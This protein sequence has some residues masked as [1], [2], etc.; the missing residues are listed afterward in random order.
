MNISRIGL[1]GL[2]AGGMKLSWDNEEEQN[3]INAIQ[4]AVDHGINWIDTA[5]LYGY[6]RSEVT[7][8]KALKQIHNKPLIFTKCGFR[9]DGN[10][11]YTPKLT[12][13]SVQEE[14]E[15][16]LKRLNIDVID[17]YQIHFPRPDEYIEEAWETMSELIKEG[18]IR[19][20]G[21]S[22][23]NVEQMDRLLKI[24]PITSHQLQYNAISCWA[25]REVLPYCLEKGIGV[26][27]YSPMASGLLTGKMNRERIANMDANDLRKKDRRYNEPNLSKNYEIVK[28]IGKIAEEK[29]CKSTEVAIAWTLNNSSV[30]GAIVGVRNPSQVMGILKGAE[31][32]LTDTDMKRISDLFYSEYDS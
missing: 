10:K 5:P 9:W 3:S 31:V 26:I 15:M 12:A 17:L 25:E 32:E 16:S 19:Y 27:A 18:K 29:N 7:I 4:T 14:V 28:I 8:C 20:I 6:G 21:V 2:L 11:E 1:G 23:H 30:T 24:A 13:Q 22:N